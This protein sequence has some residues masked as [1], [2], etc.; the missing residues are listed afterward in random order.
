MGARSMRIIRLHKNTS[1]ITKQLQNILKHK[2]TH[3]EEMQRQTKSNAM[4][5]TSAHIHYKIVKK[6]KLNAQV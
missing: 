1:K 4:E 6:K 3:D 2:H 5:E